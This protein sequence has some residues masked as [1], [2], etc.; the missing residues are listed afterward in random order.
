[1]EIR[2]AK[3]EDL[4]SMSFRPVDKP[5]LALTLDYIAGV[6]KRSERAWTVVY[7]DRPAAV[8]GVVQVDLADHFYAW[9]VTDEIVNRHKMKFIR[10][11]KSLVPQLRERYGTLVADGEPWLRALGF[12]PDGER[13][14]L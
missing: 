5:G 2:A 4:Q 12:R 8:F 7:E 14:I 9:V 3:I 1:M 11:C 13:Y 10:V 6:L